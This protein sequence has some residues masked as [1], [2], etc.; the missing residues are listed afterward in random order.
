MATAIALA[1]RGVTELARE[2]TV[3]HS[4]WIFEPRQWRH[5]SHDV[6]PLSWLNP[7]YSLTV[8]SFAV[9]SHATASQ[10]NGC[11]HM[12]SLCDFFSGNIY[13]YISYF[14]LFKYS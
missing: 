3:M 13:L 5:T 11:R 1:N 6:S 10:S 12:A 7:F 14:K 2:P 8:G 4:K 9:L